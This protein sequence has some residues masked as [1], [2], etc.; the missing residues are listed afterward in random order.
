MGIRINNAVENIK[1]ESKVTAQGI[2]TIVA[3]QQA[4]RGAALYGF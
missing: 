4:R 1:S 2:A 3:G